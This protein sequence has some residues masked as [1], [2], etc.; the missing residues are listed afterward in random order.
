MLLKSIE[1]LEPRFRVLVYVA[2]LGDEENTFQL[3]RFVPAQYEQPLVEATRELMSIPKKERNQVVLKELKKM[4]QSQKMT[5]LSEIDPGW[6]IESLK[7]ERPQTIGLILRNLPTEKVKHIV[8]HLPPEI[9][10]K[11]PKM[12]EALKV[13]D[14][15]MEIVR[16]RF[17]SQFPALNA[18]E[19]T[20]EIG[21]HHFYFIRI[22]ALL[23][24]FKDLGL[25]QLARAFK[26]I[27]KV[28]LKALLNRLPIKDAKEFQQKV[29]AMDKVSNRELKEAQMLLLNLPLETMDPEDLF[30]EV[31]MAFFSKAV[32]REDSDLIRALEYKLPPKYGYLLK[33]Y[34]DESLG[35][36]KPGMIEWVKKQV[37]D[38]F[39]NFPTD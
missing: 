6:F 28:A 22:E 7:A 12:N 1:N 3:F 16:S 18:P 10:K 36:N 8:S 29:K 24:L 20:E 38:K 15:V 2:S 37:L 33:R 11:L 23:A 17:E 5:L 13:S 26:G 21:L 31:G 14:E 39:Q 35:A 32:S 27:H 9:R 34:V 25:E 30:L 19:R 4:I